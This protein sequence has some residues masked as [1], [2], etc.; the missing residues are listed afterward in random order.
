MLLH[1]PGQDAVR[2]GAGSQASTGGLLPQ[3]GPNGTQAAPWPGSI[4]V[5]PGLGRGC[6][7][8]SE[9]QW[10]GVVGTMGI[11]GRRLERLARVL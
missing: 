9:S 11:S 3:G 10:G 5:S 4:G 8:R 1:K 2:T 6:L 7:D